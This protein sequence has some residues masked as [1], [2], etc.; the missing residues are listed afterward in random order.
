VREVHGVARVGEERQLVALRAPQRRDAADHAR[1]V[2]A[3]FESEA[4]CKFVDAIAG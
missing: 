1:R 3:R 4:P 2:A